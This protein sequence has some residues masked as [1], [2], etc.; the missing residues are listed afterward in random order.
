M[1][2]ETKVDTEITLLDKQEQGTILINTSTKGSPVLLFW[3][4]GFGINLYIFKL[5]FQTSWAYDKKVALKKHMEQDYISNFKSCFSLS[6][7]Y[8]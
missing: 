5:A 3:K 8:A 1:G 2:F 6:F 4:L 7:E